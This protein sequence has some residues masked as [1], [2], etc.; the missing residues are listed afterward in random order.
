[1]KTIKIYETDSYI[2]VFKATVLSCEKTVNGYAIILDRTAFF[3]EGGGQEADTGIIGTAKINDVQIIDGEVVHFSS[4]PLPLECVECKIDWDKRFRR[5]QNHT[6]E[7]ILSGIASKMFGCNNVGFHMGNEITVD[8]D[9]ELNNQQIKEIEN[10]A[11]KA[12]Y[13]NVPVTVDFPSAETLASMDYRSKLE[14]TED[15]RIVTVEGYDVC[16]CCAPHVSRSGEIGIIKVLSSARHRGGVRLEI[17]CGTDAFEDYCIKADNL[18]EIAVTLCA[19]HNEELAA[20]RKLC[21]ENGELKQKIA[22]LSKELTAL[23][24]QNNDSI[25]GFNLFFDTTDDMQAVRSLA[26]ES[27]KA[28]EGVTAVF[29]GSEGSYK[30]AIASFTKSVKPIMSELTTLFKARG[31]GSDE[32]VQGNISATEE[33]LRDFFGKVSL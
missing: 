26:L 31:G 33:E 6:G 4:A 9:I 18:Y 20:F 32:L 24:A 23:K 14:L 17:L 10:A 16:A 15:V 21:N 30:F 27:A 2:S 13:D 25:N 8:F 22:A 12:I 5:M 3:P 1:M 19:K 28:S 11:N 7:H 29:S